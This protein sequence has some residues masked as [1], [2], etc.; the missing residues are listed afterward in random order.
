[1]SFEYMTE[2]SQFL[3]LA[4]CI[5]AAAAVVLFFSLDIP[6]CFRMVFG[7]LAARGGKLRNTMKETVK[8]EGAD[9]PC[10]E[11]LAGSRETVLLEGGCAET[12]A[13]SGWC[14]DERAESAGCWSAERRDGYEK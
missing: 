4:A 3:F 6:G 9:S 7:R 13:L 5:F 11:I 1:M 12:L 2:V 10:T 14:E 8:T